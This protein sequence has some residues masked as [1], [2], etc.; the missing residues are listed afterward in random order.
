MLQMLRP[1]LQI[2]HRTKMATMTLSHYENICDKIRSDLT[3]PQ[4]V[5]IALDAWSSPQRVAYLGVLVY[6]I[7]NKFQFREHL[8]G[9]TPL[10]IEHTDRQLTI[11]LM[12]ILENYGI[13]DKLFGVVTDN[14]SNNSTLKDELEK[15][16]SRREFRWDRTQNSINCLAHVINLVAQDFI[17]ALGSK[18][19]ADN[20]I[21]QL[22]NE[23]VQDI[24]AS[25]GLSVVVKK[26]WLQVV[27]QKGNAFTNHE[28]RFAL[29]R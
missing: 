5:S 27:M 10:D 23:Q 8:I 15:A 24:E 16:M 28:I 13:K 29:W 21:M 9:F 14:A 1:D 12:K 4:R 11:E 3:E 6:W 7:D 26:V 19:I 18:A 2:M 20:V 22:K 25:Q 17:Q